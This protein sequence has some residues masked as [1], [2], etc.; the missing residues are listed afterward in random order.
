VVHAFAERRRRVS[1]AAADAGID[2]VLVTPGPDLRYLTGYSAVALERLTCLVLPADAEP[3]LLVPELELP[4]ALASPAAELEVVHWAETDD[5][6]QRAAD[7]AGHVTS[8]AVDDRMW[9]EK[10][11]RFR[12]ALPH[13]RQVS[14]GALLTEQRMRKD[15]TEIAHLAEAAAAIDAVHAQMREWLRPGRT[16]HDVAVDVDR[17]ILAV[18]HVHT[19]FVIVASGPNGAS[20]HHEPSQRV[21]EPGDT[22]V[23]DIGG[24]MPSGYRSDSTRTYAIGEPSQVAWRQY[25]VL[26]AAQD[27]AVAAVRPGAEAQ[28]VDSAARSL[29]AEAGYGPLFVHRTGHGIGV[30]THENPYIVAGSTRVLE[31]GM[32]FSVEPGIYDPGHQGAR[33]EDIVAVTEDGVRRLNARPRDLV[34]L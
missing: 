28:Q 25:Q 14:A 5:P 3:T 17:G 29:I 9:A 16:E 7:I 18:G 30:E 12:D 22:V 23:V 2:V 8:M 27:A 26:Q 10:V 6:V 19:D 15:A 32:V 31:P 1:R 34:L 33:I 4:A 13:A 11:L 24:E 21:I 20:P